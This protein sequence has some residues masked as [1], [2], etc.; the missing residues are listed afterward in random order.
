MFFS[1]AK[2]FRGLRSSLQGLHKFSIYPTNFRSKSPF[3]RWTENIFGPSARF[4]S[5]QPILGLTHLSC[6][7][8]PFFAFFFPCVL[9]VST[10]PAS[11]LPPYRL[12]LLGGPSGSSEGLRAGQ[13]IA[14][15]RAQD[16]ALKA[17]CT[18]HRS[19]FFLS[20]YIFL[21]SARGCLGTQSSHP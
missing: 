3:S 21:F 1:Y 19:E 8:T 2:L 10:P 16:R 20:T 4:R 12:S 17:T 11:F 6:S 9:Y 14:Y 13:N 18:P 7:L 5:H 15:S